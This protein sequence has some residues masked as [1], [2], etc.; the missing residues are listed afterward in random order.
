MSVGADTVIAMTS[1]ETNL[2]LDRSQRAV[3]DAP[4]DESL[5][6]VGAPG[7]GKT[8]TLVELLL[9]RVSSGAT[10]PDDVLA[11]VPARTQAATLRDRIAARLGGT[12]SGA[13]ARTPQSLA[14]EIVRES[15]AERGREAPALLTGAD[16]DALIRDLTEGTDDAAAR[17]DFAAP[18]TNDV[19]RL[20]GF[21][22]E[23]RDLKTAMHEFDVTPDE[24]ASYAA[25]RPA[26]RGAA[27][28]VE[29]LETVLDWERDGAYDVPS[30]L[31]E[32]ASILHSEPVGQLA[33]DRVRLVAVDD[34][35]ELTEAARRLL[36]ALE[37]RGATIV[38]FGDPDIAT[39][40]FRGGGAERATGWRPSDV[41]PARR[42][43]LRT[44]HRHG[45]VIRQLVAGVTGRIGV[46]GEGGHRQASSLAGDPEEEA[47]A[48]GAHPVTARG[49]ESM[50]GAEGTVRTALAESA[51]A[52]AKLIASQLRRLHLA[53]G[54]AWNDMAVLVRSGASVPTLARL[55]AR[56][57]VPTS[58]VRAPDAA[59]DPAVVAIVGIAEAAANPELVTGERIGAFLESPLFGIDGMR[60]RQ[61]RRALRRREHAAGGE[62]LADELLVD[63]VRSP[64]GAVDL[65]APESAG[66]DREELS[67]PARHPAVVALRRLAS[68]LVRARDVAREGAA[69]EVLWAVW[70][71]AGVADR[72]RRRAIAGGVEG[73]AA[74]ARLDAV[75]ALFD[76]AKRAV[77]RSPEVSIENFIASWAA[78]DVATD[79]LARRADRDAVTLATPASVVGRE[80][81]AVVVAGVS[82]GTWP[83]LRLRDTLLGAQHLIELVTSRAD[84][85]SIV[86]RRRDVLDDES[87]MFAQ[88]VS[89]A[90]EWLLVTA[91]ES[92]DGGP[93][94][95]FRRLDAPRLDAG[96]RELP[97][98]LRDLTGHLRRRLRERASRGGP[99]EL[100]SAALGRLAA[101]GV[102]EA[103][104]ASWHGIREPSTTRTLVNLTP[105]GDEWD[106]IAVSPSQIETFEACGI[107]WFIG[108]YGG[109]DTSPEMSLGT[110][111]HAGAEYQFPTREARQQ[112]LEG[113]LD[114]VSAEAPWRAK[115]MRARLKTMLDGLDQYLGERRAMGATP[116][117]TERPF[118]VEIPID[119]GGIRAIAQL[120]GMIDRI[121]EHPEAGVRIVD[122]K[123]SRTAVTKEEAATHAQ[124]AAYQFAA[125]RATIGLQRPHS[126]EPPAPPVDQGGIVDIAPDGIEKAALVYV[127][128]GKA[129]ERTQDAMTE[130]DEAQFERRVIRA[131]LGM[132][133]LTQT[134]EHHEV[135]IASDAVAA[136][137]AVPEHHCEAEFGGARACR[138][139]IIPEVTE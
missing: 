22:T 38:T 59:L 93:S 37:E 139:H 18:I 134:E 69:D 15:R 78:R 123:T 116:T 2:V 49:I 126:E 58:A 83:N 54:V 122:F 23:L 113:R 31:L 65:D 103:D 53:D 8:T 96:S 32:A 105:E 107:D 45:P 47:A 60:I 91:V 63:E 10:G 3:V 42:L 110:L 100:V 137:H 81:R 35:Q 124:L 6:V 71:G 21:R 70:E 102:F 11:L 34:A 131:A 133:G 30:L 43:L 64:L 67:L 20:G 114:E 73:E 55:L 44:V 51:V 136:F 50:I 25:H 36:V 108:R 109:R 17:Y 135:A 92:E 121:E 99:V 62:R 52:E 46:R 84:D 125:R 132:A 24:L 72:W 57:E 39:G 61:L 118:V 7:T 94:I 79:S 85:A 82:E 127:A 40:T 14:F 90:R 19:L 138:I 98:T 68:M 66:A 97:S 27:N 130:H 112:Y 117:A 95:L 77:E 1:F 48:P 111:V 76:V 26:W 119:E 75:V 56:A 5:V 16:D 115:A 89:R 80:F 9:H 106:S 87:R 101:S 28:L 86:D 13:R 129:S 41:A 104:P 4:V 74:D 88:A 120:R 33:V 128:E 29:E 12:V